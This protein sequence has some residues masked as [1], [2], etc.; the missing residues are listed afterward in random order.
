MSQPS[1]QN[2]TQSPAA[3]V[4]VSLRIPETLETEIEE[5]ASATLL[6]KPDVMRQAMRLGLRVL[7]AALQSP[8]ASPAAVE[9]PNEAAA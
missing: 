5:A 3:G 4:P 8:P 1:I 2:Q 7:V 9:A 6:S